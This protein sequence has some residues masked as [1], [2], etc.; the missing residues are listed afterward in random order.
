M[1]SQTTLVFA[2]GYYSPRVS[3]N[4]RWLVAPTYANTMEV[5]NMTTGQRTNTTKGYSYFAS[6]LAIS[7][8]GQ[9]K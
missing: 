2:D 6:S 4:G 9:Q 8:N 3:R 5:W 1:A 7:P